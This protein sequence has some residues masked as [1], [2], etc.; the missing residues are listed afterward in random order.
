MNW[1]SVLLAIPGVKALVGLAYRNAY[2]SAY[3]TA[4]STGHR[5]P[6]AP[7]AASFDA[8]REVIQGLDVSRGRAILGYWNNPI[9]RNIADNRRA[10]TIGAEIQFRAAVPDGEI[11]GLSSDQVEQINRRLTGLYRRW[12]DR[13]ECDAT[14]AA[15]QGRTIG[16]F[17]GQ[18]FLDSDVRGAVLIHAVQRP[19][20]SVCP[21]AFELIP[22]TR[23]RRP[24]GKPG[25]PI[26]QKLINDAGI[27]FADPE[28]SRVI[29]YWVSIG[30]TSSVA[31]TRYAFLPAEWTC[32]L[33]TE[34]LQGVE[35]GQPRDV[36]IAKG[37]QNIA[38]FTHESIQAAREQAK[39]PMTITPPETTTADNFAAALSDGSQ[40]KPGGSG[41]ELF[42]DVGPG[43]S[44][45]VMP[46]GAK[47]ERHAVS[48]P[49]P[50]L[51]EFYNA[52][53]RFIAAGAGMSPSR[54]VRMAPP[55]Y[56]GGRN[57]E[58]SDLPQI[59]IDRERFYSAGR[60]M[61]AKFVESCWA[62]GAISLPGF[63]D[64]RAAYEACEVD[65]PAEQALNPVD[66]F[67]ALSGRVRAGYSSEFEA[68]AAYGRAYETV[69]R[70]R[71][72]AIQLRR[73]IEIEAGLDPGELDEAPLPGSPIP[74]APPEPPS[75]PPSDD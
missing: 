63:L 59:E 3:I 57:D 69:L 1:R 50:G 43:V 25:G 38:E 36:A 32:L 37:L 19:G 35:I 75:E 60:W 22:V 30:G 55:N 2:R 74:A 45:R 34:A 8:N 16:T 65:Y 41:S 47:A 31:A 62:F 40:V 11:V 58:Q 56:S 46:P 17:Q 5:P 20:N 54:A 24:Y 73:R 4:S 18:A 67:N 14:K 52:Q 61:W 7:N 39:S 33:E 9:A 66:Q 49:A 6:A 23:M 53:G 44:A 15:G 12:A 27:Q 68:A 13:G 28:H 70:E 26:D 48:L 21:L 29:G 42:M 10:R 51:A 72:K 64:N 71:V